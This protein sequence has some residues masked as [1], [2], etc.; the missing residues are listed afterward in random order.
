VL[1]LPKKKRLV[2]RILRNGGLTC[3]IALLVIWIFADSGLIMFLA[4]A[5]AAASIAGEQ[6]IRGM[7][8]CPK[9]G[10]RLLP[11]R[12]WGGLE[13]NCPAHCSNCGE[14]IEIEISE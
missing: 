9:C 11:H 2:A 4:L 1:K 14:K 12:Y 6:M 5:F 3:T 8:T 7:Y 10:N 13:A